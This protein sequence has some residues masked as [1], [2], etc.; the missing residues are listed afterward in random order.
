MRAHGEYRCQK[1]LGGLVVISTRQ[2]GIYNIAHKKRAT[3]IITG[4]ERFVPSR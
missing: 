3:V 4:V 1:A 2:R